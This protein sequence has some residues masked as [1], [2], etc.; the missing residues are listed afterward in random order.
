MS[1]RH[2][3]RLRLDRSPQEH[4]EDSQV[5]FRLGF[6]IRVGKAA[7]LKSGII[8]ILRADIFSHICFIFS[9]VGVRVGKAA[10]L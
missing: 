3:Y 8:V 6:V 10:G 5:S 7:G 1:F 2:G 4:S 9:F